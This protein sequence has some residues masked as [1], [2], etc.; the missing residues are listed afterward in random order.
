ME[1]Q[2]FQDIV[3]KLNEIKNKVNIPEERKKD[4]SKAIDMLF[5]L[6]SE[7]QELQ[8]EVSDLRHE[9]SHLNRE[10]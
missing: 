7:V 4:I 2:K 6:K 9:I 1:G 10:N 8:F 5:I 3:D